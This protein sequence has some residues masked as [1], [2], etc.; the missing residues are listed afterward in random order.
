MEHT[1][2]LGLVCLQDTSY[3]LGIGSADA[4][5]S[6]DVPAAPTSAAMTRAPFRMI[7]SLDM[8]DPFGFT[9]PTPL[10]RPVGPQPGVRN[11]TIL[12]RP[13]PVHQGF[14][15]SL[16]AIDR[17]EAGQ[18]LQSDENWAPSP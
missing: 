15:Y 8:R 13:A 2:W 16:E 1:T 14:H 17:G 10:A 3:P 7:M 4:T 5:G 9:V 18:L 6:S 11:P 12:S